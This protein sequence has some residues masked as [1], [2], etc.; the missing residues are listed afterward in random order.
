MEEIFPEL[1]ALQDPVIVP[2]K[3]KRKKAEKFTAPP[4]PKRDEQC[5]H[6]FW[7][8][9]CSVCKIIMESDHQ[10]NVESGTKVKTVYDELQGLVCSFDISKQLEE[11]DVYQRSK[12]YW[13]LS[14][15]YH[16]V[17]L[18]VKTEVP[19]KNVKFFSAFTSSELCNQLYRLPKRR[20]TP[21]MFEKV[22]K[23]AHQPDKL[24]KLLILELKIKN[25]IK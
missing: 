9:R 18:R 17:S 8:K 15:E 11:L 7:I 5:K 14:Y 4:D 25:N 20:K 12:L 22:G 19:L 1:G 23:L 6:M 2:F 13:V 3:Q 10:K 24:A 21:E 16:S